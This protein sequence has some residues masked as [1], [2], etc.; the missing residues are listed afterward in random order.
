MSR[1]KV[2]F[3]R[4][5]SRTVDDYVL[6]GWMRCSPIA[7]SLSG[8]NAQLTPNVYMSPEV[9]FAGRSKGSAC[10][11][12][13]WV[14]VNMPSTDLVSVIVPVYRTEA[15]LNE[16]VSSILSQ[17]YAHI[18]VILV[19]DGSDDA[20]PLLCD[21]WAAEDPRVQVIHQRNGGVS[22]ARNRGLDRAKGDFVA[23]VD[24]DD[25]IAKDFLEVLHGIVLKHNADIASCDLSSFSQDDPVFLRASESITGPAIDVMIQLIRAGRNWE[26]WGK[27][28]RRSQFDNG[29]R[30]RVGLHY[31]EDLAILP[32]IYYGASSAA[33]TQSRLYGYRQRDDGAMGASRRTLSPDLI[34][35]LQENIA[36]VDSRFQRGTSVH[37][38]L[39]AVFLLHATT[40]LEQVDPASSKTEN[41]AYIAS[42]RSFMRRNLRRALVAREISLPYRVAIALSSVSPQAFLLA[43]RV[44]RRVKA[45]LLPPLRRRTGG[46]SNAQI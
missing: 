20:S 22:A 37:G 21:Q 31:A 35:V 11:R 4:G 5:F 24:S 12:R 41:S 39:T 38:I 43:F 28:F 10:A 44:A 33:H 26:V 8:F 16:C 40:K 14:S 17:T 6:S 32:S 46:A 29:L 34:K 7:T 42:Y 30:F 1:K 3:G 15:Y 45:S 36:L 9:Q 23:F 18:E 25:V 13:A 19:D 2:D 27:L